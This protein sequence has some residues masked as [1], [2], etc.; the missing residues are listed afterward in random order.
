MNTTSPKAQEKAG[1]VRMALTH[2]EGDRVP[3]GEF[4]WTGFLQRCRKKW[5]EDF[6]PYRHFDLDYIVITPNMDPR[7]EPFTILESDDQ[8]VVVRTGF[9]ATI[10]RTAEA[11]MPGFESFSVTEAEGMADFEWGDPRDPRRFHEGGDDQ[12]NGVGDAL[13]RDLPAWDERVNAYVEDFAVFGSVCEPYE[14]LWRII[15]SEN[16]L[17]WMASEPDRFAAFV[18]RVGAFLLEFCQA[19]IEAARGRLMGMY[20]WGDVAYRGGMFFGLPRWR[21]LFKPHVKALIDC[22]RRH[23]LLTVYHGCGKAS[24]IFDDLQELG[25]HAYNPL[26]AKAGLDVVVLKKRYAGKLAFVGNIDVRVLETGDEEA[27]RREVLYK[28]RAA[29]GGGW[30]FQSD[31]SV[32]SQ[33][34]P[35]IYELALRVL[36][37]NGNFPLRLV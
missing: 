29:A 17:V 16:A 18:D 30:I 28:L 11:P 5:G 15:G 21:T 13:I 37:E 22:C 35:E 7:V 33:V 19:Q 2:Q 9:G 8:H 25:L 10:R 12:I 26:E 36:R 20:I 23:G 14:Y 31:H 1:R 34:R 3:A 24:A 27:V 4:F 32:T 6:D